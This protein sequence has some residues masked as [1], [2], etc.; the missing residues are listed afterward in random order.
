MA[1]LWKLLSPVAKRETL[2]KFALKEFKGH[3]QDKD[4][5]SMMVIRVY[6]GSWRHT[7]CTPQYP[8]FM[9]SSENPELCHTLMHAFVA[10]ASASLHAHF[11]FGGV[12]R[13]PIRT[14]PAWIAGCL[15]ELLQIFG[16]TWSMANH[17]AEQELASLS[18]ANKICAVLIEDSKTFMFGAKQVI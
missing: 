18:K 11:V 8:P 3:V 7:V 13:P 5:L 15:Q 17:E 14:A 9:Q 2:M 1:D 16:F 4:G 10:L 6:A 12:D